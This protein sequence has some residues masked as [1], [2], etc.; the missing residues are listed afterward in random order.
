MTPVMFNDGMY[1]AGHT[2]AGRL[3]P[4][5]LCSYCITGWPGYDLAPARLIEKMGH[6]II[7]TASDWYYVLG[8]RTGDGGNQDF[9]SDKTAAGIARVAKSEVP[10]GAD[11]EPAGEML[12]VWCDEPMAPYTAEERDILDRLIGL[13]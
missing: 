13:F 10:G 1:Y 4:D 3:D 8:R 11:S 9:T 5:I 7:N 2:E 6:R 12:C